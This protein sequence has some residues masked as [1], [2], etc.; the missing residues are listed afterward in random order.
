MTL[1]SYMS[2]VVGH[3]AQ[4]SRS[5]RR[6]YAHH[7]PS[8]GDLR[9]SVVKKFLLEHLPDRFGVTTGFAI[10]VGGDVSRQAD[11][12]VVDKMNNSPLY[13]GF[14]NELWPIESIYAIIEVKTNLV[15]SAI[16]DAILKAKRF[17]SIPRQFC[18]TRTSDRYTD[19]SLFVIWGF[20]CPKSTTLKTNLNNAVM[21][22]PVEL[23]PDM[24]VVPDRVVATSGIYMQTVK[25]GEP[26]SQ[27]RR[28]LTE[29]HGS[30]LA[31][32]I[33]GPAE[34]MQFDADS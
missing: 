27:F 26:N 6:D 10:S 4:T 15:R 25:I 23:Q 14:G 16:N 21:T 1:P 32:L 22:T 30:D 17:K 33:P 12:M 18:E 13:G 19:Q 5:I 3:M 7:R 34:V 31:A 20:E 24:L 2:D 11:L 29:Q 8:A 9:E 28:E